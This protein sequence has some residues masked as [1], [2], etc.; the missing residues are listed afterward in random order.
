[1]QRHNGVVRACSS[2]RATEPV[3]GL[4]YAFGMTQQSHDAVRAAL[5]A[6]DAAVDERDTAARVLQAR[7]D[8]AAA[9]VA[10]KL[11]VLATALD[12]ADAPMDR[13]LAREVYWQAPHVKVQALAVPLRVRVG[14][15]HQVVGELDETVTCR[16]GCGKAL[17][18]KLT[19]RAGAQGR[20]AM[21]KA[22]CDE[23]RARRDRA[24]AERSRIPDAHAEYV[25]DRMND[26]LRAGDE[27]RPRYVEFEGLPG[28]WEVNDEGRPVRQL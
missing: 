15:V 10:G 28:T 5:V 19:S 26:A 12:D 24:W 6:Y 9:A 2:R 18:I 22:I 7:V 8:A 14:E 16:G 11:A 23:C 25:D 21:A 27:L 1:M 20:P 13:E 17:T 4:T 3:G